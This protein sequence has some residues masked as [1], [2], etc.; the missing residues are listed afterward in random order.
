MKIIAT[1]MTFALLVTSSAQA[2][3]REV[4]VNV[5]HQVENYYAATGEW[6]L[7]KVKKIEHIKDCSLEFVLLSAKAH[8]KNTRTGR[9]LTETCLVTFIADDGEFFAINC[10]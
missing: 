7:V 9:S 6:N 10:F 3:E 2:I 5:R 8:I 1:L 4:Y